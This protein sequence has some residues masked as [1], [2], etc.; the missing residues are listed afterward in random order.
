MRYTGEIARGVFF[1]SFFRRSLEYLSSQQQDKTGLIVGGRLRGA[2]RSRR[3]I[4]IRRGS[5]II[6][7]GGVRAFFLSAKISCH[8]AMALLATLDTRRSY[9]FRSWHT[10]LGHAENC[11][12]CRAPPPY[13][14]IQ[15]DECELK[16]KSMGFLRFPLKILRVS[17]LSGN[18]YKHETV[19]W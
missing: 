10:R 13:R 3:R 11:S 1:F 12:S 9:I 8:S 15:S 6:Y 16:L 5:F 2:S 17:T 19:M 4:L 7:G 14:Y 18:Y